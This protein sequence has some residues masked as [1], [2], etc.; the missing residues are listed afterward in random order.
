MA[1]GAN[2]L[3]KSFAK[4]PERAKELLKVGEKPRDESLDLAQH[5]AWT[6]I[7]NLLLNLDEV[8]TRG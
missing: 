2:V 5:A 1:Q 8:V 6:V 4:E 7:A 3:D